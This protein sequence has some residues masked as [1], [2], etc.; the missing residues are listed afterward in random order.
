MKTYITYTK[1]QTKQIKQG[2]KEGETLQSLAQKLSNEWN[3]P[4]S[5]IYQKIR[6]VSKTKRKYVRRAP[7]TTPVIKTTGVELTGAIKDRFLENFKNPS[8]VV[9]YGDHIRYYFN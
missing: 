9:L 1:E 3:I 4:F 7:Q 2:L 8:K 5:S 6:R